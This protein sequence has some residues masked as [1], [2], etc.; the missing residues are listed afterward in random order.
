VE[1]CQ[2]F[3]KY[4]RTALDSTARLALLL[5]PREVVGRG[6][7]EAVR[8]VPQADG[9]VVPS[10]ECSNETQNAS[11]LDA[12]D[13]LLAGAVLEVADGEEEEG[14]VEEEEEEEESKRGPEGADDQDGVKDE[15]ADQVEAQ[16]VLEI[17]GAGRV[18]GDDAVAVATASDDVG[19][20]DP[21]A[22]VRRERGGSEGVADGKFP[23]ASKELNQTTIAER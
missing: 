16:G 13:V 1:S 17:L 2:I 7:D 8:R 21:E 15:P 11:C 4:S 14:E 10:N 3:I 18:T 6:V 5:A 22:A 23:H 20:A 19:V 12:V 9:G